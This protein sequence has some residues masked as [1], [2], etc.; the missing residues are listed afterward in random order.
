MNDNHNNLLT[1]IPNLD[2]G[3]DFQEILKCRNV[4]IERIVSSSQP[5]SITY[6][7]QQDEWVLLLQ[8]EATLEMNGKIINLQKGDYLFIPTQTPHRVVKTSTQPC[9]IWLA[10]HIY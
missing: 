1:N 3:E 10:I 9:C 7:Q 4:K 6:N 2:I 8:G 5:E